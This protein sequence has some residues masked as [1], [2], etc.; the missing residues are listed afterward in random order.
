MRT[1]RPCTSGTRGV[2]SPGPRRLPM[3][4]RARLQLDRRCVASG[5]P[6]IFPARLWHLVHRGRAFIPARVSWTAWFGGRCD[7][8]GRPP[9]QPRLAT[10]RLLSSDAPTANR[11]AYSRSQEFP[12]PA[13]TT[14]RRERVSSFY[15]PQ[16]HLDGP[17][18]RRK[19]IRACFSGDGEADHRLPR[20]RVR[21]DD[22]GT[23]GVGCVTRSRR[24]TR[25]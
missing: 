7:V 14:P 19:F 17:P 8:I 24:T 6:E 2:P 5:F 12:C 9:G 11:R 3:R 4:V 25:R 22:G 18:A 13:K 1:N 15:P 21:R 23:E 10:L 16:R 20:S